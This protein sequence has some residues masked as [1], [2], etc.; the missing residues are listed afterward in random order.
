MMTQIPWELLEDYVKGD[1]IKNSGVGMLFLPKDDAKLKTA[2]T[3]IEAVCAKN[4]IEVFLV[5]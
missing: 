5:P 1:D 3:A 4:E 2:K